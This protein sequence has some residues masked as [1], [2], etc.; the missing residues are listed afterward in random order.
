MNIGVMQ[1]MYDNLDKQT[2]NTKIPLPRTNELIKSLREAGLGSF[3][4]ATK[5]HEYLGDYKALFP[6]EII[7]IVDGHIDY[8][9]D[10]KHTHCRNSAWPWIKEEDRQK[11]LELV[12]CANQEVYQK[13][14]NFDAGQRNLQAKL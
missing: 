10:F 2:L 6:I 9:K 7:T 13:I 1:A 4:T 11:I 5:I 14:L 8:Y 3:V 12:F